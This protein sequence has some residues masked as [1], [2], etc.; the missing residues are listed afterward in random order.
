[1]FEVEHKEENHH[2]IK[3]RDVDGCRGIKITCAG[4]SCVFEFAV[5]RCKKA[6]RY[7]H[8]API[9]SAPPV[10]ITPALHPAVYPAIRPA[11]KVAD[12]QGA[13]SSDIIDEE[14]T[15]N[16]SLN[17][18]SSFCTTKSRSLDDGAVK[19]EPAEATCV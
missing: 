11:K 9:I 3:H 19:L 6:V 8:P 5:F 12:N 10:P 15:T 1:M 13:A 16:V 7:Q 14:A 17:S 4:I 2:S 18:S